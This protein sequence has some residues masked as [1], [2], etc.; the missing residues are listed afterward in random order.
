MI[1]TFV[2]VFVCFCLNL[3][4][5]LAWLACQS[6]YFHSRMLTPCL[7]RL[8]ETS[9]RFLLSDVL[10]LLPMSLLQLFV[11]FQYSHSAAAPSPPPLLEKK[12]KKSECRTIKKVGWWMMGEIG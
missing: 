5:M 1:I 11:L 8:Y 12:K 2:F 9:K 6:R 10:L 4:L 7:C 3:Q